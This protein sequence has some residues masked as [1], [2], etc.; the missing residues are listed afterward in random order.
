MGARYFVS[1]Y[2]RNK[3]VVEG[4]IGEPR[5]AVCGNDLVL[6]VHHIDVDKI[7]IFVCPNHYIPY[8]CG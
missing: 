8:R 3:L 5:C 6:D 2:R 7:A 1:N 4:L